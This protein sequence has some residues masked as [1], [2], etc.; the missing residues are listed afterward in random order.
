M[1]H[2]LL[3]SFHIHGKVFRVANNVYLSELFRIIEGAL[4]LDG[5][6]VRNYA[7]LLADKLAADGDE[8]SAQRLRKIL[9]ERAVQLHPSRLEQQTP[10]PVD[11]ESR[12][13][14]LDKVTVPDSAERHFFTDAQRAFVDDYLAVVGSRAELEKKGI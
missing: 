14:L 11:G 1:L 10:P 4:R 5:V 8:A 7:S 9:D 6:K 12:F 3:T 2:K 13:P